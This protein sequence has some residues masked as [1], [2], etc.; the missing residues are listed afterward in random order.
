MSDIFELARSRMT[1]ANPPKKVTTFPI[2]GT[3]IVTNVNRYSNHPTRTESQFMDWAYCVEYYVIGTQS[4]QYL[5]LAHYQDDPIE[6]WI[7]ANMDDFEDGG[8]PLAID[9]VEWW[10]HHVN[11]ISAMIE[12]HEKIRKYY[13][14][15]LNKS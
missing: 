8:E 3:R 7:K 6:D 4:G 9:K 14:E 1:D 10:G 12:C 2:S 5:V 15:V 13:F 11:P